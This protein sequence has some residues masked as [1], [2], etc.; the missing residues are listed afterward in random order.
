MRFEV[1]AGERM[2]IASD[3]SITA[4][5]NVDLTDST[6]DVYSQTTN[7]SSKTFQLFSDIGGT[8]TEKVFITANGSASFEGAVGIGTTSPGHP[9]QVE[10]T[11]TGTTAGSNSCALFQSQASGRDAH[12]RFGD[13]V[14]ATARIGYLSNNL[15]AYVNGDE[16]LRIDSSGRL[17]VGASTAR[18]GFFGDGSVVPNIQLEVSGSR[19]RQAWITNSNDGQSPEIIVAKSRGTSNGGVTV[20]QNNDELG[21]FSFQG[22]DGTDFVEAARIQAF[23]DGTPGVNDMPGRLVFSTTA[24]GSASPTKRMRISSNGQSHYF[25]D[26]SFIFR[27]VRTGAGDAFLSFQS[28]ATNIE[29]GTQKCRILADGDLENTNNSYGALSDVKLKENIVDAESQW[30]DLKGIN[31]RNYNFKEELGFG[32]NTHIGV[33]AQELELVSP[34][35]VKTIPDRD[36]DDNDLGTTTKSVK[37]SVLYMKAVKALQEAMERIETLEQRLSDAGIA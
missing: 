22:T 21:M 1:A 4:A 37:Y 16:R 27:T 34:N 11:G 24:S 28:G 2:R 35:L 26:S 25:S 6:V 8:K 10:D 13:S 5:G 19:S 32:T 3:G 36:N 33:V 15:Y 12:I 7:Q 29:N 30:E 31:I 18:G 9:L 23:V 17:L 20:V 14:N